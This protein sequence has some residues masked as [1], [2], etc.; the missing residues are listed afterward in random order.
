MRHDDPLA[1][2]VVLA[3]RGGDLATLRQLLADHAGL[4]TA[5]IVDDGG[6]AR[7]LL[8]V[9]TDWPARC[10]H[11]A[12]TLALLVSAGA[13]VNARFQGAHNETP[14]HWA[15]SA[16]DVVV[17]DALLD[18][19]ADIDADGAVIGGG[20]PLA[21]ARAFAQWNAAHR[22]VERGATVTLTDAATLGLSD[23]LERLLAGAAG[24]DVNAA[25]WGACHGGQRECAE[26]LLAAGA[27]VDWLP[28]W[29]RLTPLDAAVRNGFEDVAA[30]LRSRGGRPA[31]G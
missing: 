7:T 28:P 23:R 26:R 10:P 18:A 16:D 14:L 20:T 1:H 4:A 17:L 24:E 2:A 19:G 15:A 22:L 8:H 31:T 3:V 11:G 12:E 30:W 25:F 6:N 29:E 5:R 9:L 21:D 13:D 27:D